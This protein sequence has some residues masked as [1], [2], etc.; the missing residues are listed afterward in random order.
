MMIKRCYYLP[1]VKP[2]VHPRPTDTMTDV[3]AQGCRHV[4]GSAPRTGVAYIDGSRC[5][6]RYLTDT[7]STREHDEQCI[8]RTYALTQMHGIKSTGSLFFPFLFFSFRAAEA[9]ELLCR[10]GDYLT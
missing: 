10:V 6:A 4:L 9:G 5:A 1:A 3:V 8:I 7:N 2:V